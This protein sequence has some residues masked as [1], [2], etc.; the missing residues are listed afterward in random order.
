[1]AQPTKDEAY[2]DPDASNIIAASH[3]TTLAEGFGRKVRNIILED[4]AVLGTK[5]ADDSQAAGRWSTDTGRAYYAAG[6]NVGIAGFRARLAVIDDP[7]GSW[8]DADSPLIRER[9]WEWYNEDLN[10]RMTPGSRKIIVTTRRHEDDLAGRLLARMAAGGER[11]ETLTIPAIAGF[12]DALGRKPGEWLW[13]GKY[14]YAERLRE[15]KQSSP[16]RTWSALYQ[17]TPTP[18]T[19]DFFLEQWLRPAAAVPPLE[20][21]RV[22]GAS[23]YAVTAAGGDYTA[24]VTVGI[25]PDGKMYLL[26]VWRGQAASDT[27]VEAFCDI[28]A[29]YKPTTWAEEQGQIRSGIGPYLDKRM[30]ERRVY[31]KRVQFPTRGD[32]ATRAQSIRARMAFDGLYVDVTQPWYVDL[33]AELL[34]FPAGKHDDQVDAL[35]LIGQLLDGM[36]NGAG[37][38]PVVKPRRDAYERRDDA[39]ANNWKSI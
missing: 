6:V 3:T 34:S 8:Q 18:D 38:T 23:D 32:K 20:K 25:G 9:A 7:V 13:E 29:R 15:I 16:V 26:N 28:V 12:D 14:G 31:V 37:T 2:A 39:G 30:R 36:T 11:W 5:L 17:Q 35:G 33:R 22:Y 27:W 1:M 21:L 4:A 10:P 24:L 19:G